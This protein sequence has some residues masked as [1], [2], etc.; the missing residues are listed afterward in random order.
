M[1]L[2]KLVA[3]IKGRAEPDT[4]ETEKLAKALHVSVEY[5]RIGKSERGLDRRRLT[6]PHLADYSTWVFTEMG[7]LLW[8]LQIVEGAVAQTGVI[9]F[10]GYRGMGIEKAE[11]KLAK[12]GKETL[13]RRI[14]RIK[15]CLSLS[16]EATRVLS[17]L[18]E[19]RNWFIHESYREH[20][21]D[22]RS[23]GSP[24]RLIGRLQRLGDLVSQVLS[25]LSRAVEAHVL[26]RGID[27]R[28]VEEEV[29]NRM[30]S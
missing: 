17:E 14:G 6:R 3:W 2:H 22:V 24:D 15:N 7:Q 10:D 27:P 9:L 8:Q 30:S 28:R 13:G 1:P 5:L 21:R 25:D 12:R 20:A 18:V 11:A 4:D 19:E 26:A 23:T 16:D 29:R